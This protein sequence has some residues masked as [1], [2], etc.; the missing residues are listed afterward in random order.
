MGRPQLHCQCVGRDLRV[1]RMEVRGEE[2]TGL[3]DTEPWVAL[4]VRTCGGC[5]E[6]WSHSGQLAV[7]GHCPLVVGGKGRS[8]GGC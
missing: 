4:W 5:R 2:E 6:L 1:R 3:E 8:K 7:H